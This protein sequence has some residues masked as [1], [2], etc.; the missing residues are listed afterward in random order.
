MNKALLSKLEQSLRE[1][2]AQTRTHHQIEGFDLYLHPESK[3]F[4]MNLAIP[5]NSDNWSDAVK[6]MVKYF[7]AQNLQPRLEYFDELHPDLKIALEAEGFQQDMRAPVMVLEAETFQSNKTKPK[8]TY[9]RL[10]E[11]DKHQI[12]TALRRQ[13]LAYGGTGDDSALIWLPNVLKGL[14]QNTVMFAV[15]ETDGFASGAS[16]QIGGGIGELA[17]VWT[18][19]E[20][21]KRGYAYELCHHLIEDYF[22]EGYD[23]LWLSAAEG[24][25]RLYE[26]LG[27]SPLGTQLNYSLEASKA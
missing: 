6:E 9:L 18:H 22:K 20:Q 12:E 8:G 2:A 25:Q 27:F 4:F 19:P 23:L 21:Q 24:A 7:T 16:I 3:E 11:K 14:E 17:G 26:K 1:V 13:S 5:A 10:F 15:L